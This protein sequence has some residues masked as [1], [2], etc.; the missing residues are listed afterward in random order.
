MVFHGG[1]L[2]TDRGGVA[3]DV[4][5]DD[6]RGQEDDD[7][8]PVLGSAVCAQSLKSVKANYIANLKLSPARVE[9]SRF[10]PHNTQVRSRERLS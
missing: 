7:D 5:G 10:I 2:P 1:V 3:L 6:C 4:I 9:F 8:A